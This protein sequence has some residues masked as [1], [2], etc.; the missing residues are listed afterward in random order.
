MQPFIEHLLWLTVPKSKHILACHAQSLLETSYRK[1]RWG[2]PCINHGS[3]EGLC[4]FLLSVS[5]HNCLHIYSSYSRSSYLFWMSPQTQLLGYHLFNKY[6]RSSCFSRLSSIFQSH[7]GANRLPSC[8][9]I[10]LTVCTRRVVAL[11]YSVKNI[12]NDVQQIT[13]ITRGVQ[14]IVGRA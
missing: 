13:I 11:N 2:S 6:A 3:K 7:I 5:L 14:C 12:R 1:S 8:T 10:L 4:R 9:K